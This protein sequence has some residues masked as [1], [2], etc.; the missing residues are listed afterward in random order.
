MKTRWMALTGLWLA[1]ATGACRPG[2]Q[3]LRND[4]VTSRGDRAAVVRGSTLYTAYCGGCHGANGRGD[5]PVARVINVRPADLRTSRLFETAPDDELVDRLMHGTPVSSVPRPNAIAEDLQTDAIVAYLRSLS[6]GNWELLRVG[7]FVYEGTCASCHGAYGDGD[8]ALGARNDP[9]PPNLMTARERYTDPA[10]TAL[11]E[12]GHETMLPLA[13]AFQPGDIRAVVAFVRHL[14]KGYRLYDT[15]CA[16]CHGDD[17]NGVHP[18]DLLEPAL[19][20]PP[21]GAETVVRL[22]PQ[23]TRTQALHMLRRESG[24]MPHFRETLTKSDLL[25][26]IAYL[27]RGAR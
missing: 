13:D 1:L 11:V 25:D 21:I 26:V 17:G 16:S 27:R 18:E 7:R 12:R 23:A 20:A 15:Y 2:V 22:G 24:K 10:L 3:A 4:Q 9:P 6:A 8:G 19:V 5:G 14:S